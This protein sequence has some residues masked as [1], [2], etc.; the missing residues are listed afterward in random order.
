[1]VEKTT[2]TLSA[3]EATSE[4]LLEGEGRLDA[5]FYEGRWAWLTLQ[6]ID[7]PVER[8]GKYASVFYPGR[9]KRIFVNEANGVPFMGSRNIFL[10]PPLAEKFLAPSMDVVSSLYIKR[11]WTLITRSGTVGRALHAGKYLEP[12]TITED[13]IRVVPKNIEGGYL[14]AFLCSKYGYTLMSTSQF[15]AVIMHLEP[16]HIIN[17]PLPIFDEAE[18]VEI[19]KLMQRARVLRER[20]AC[21]FAKSERNLYRLTGLPRFEDVSISYLEGNLEVDAFEV[22]IHDLAGR[23]DA[24]Y[25]VPEAHAVQSVL[26]ESPLP[27]ARLGDMATIVI[28]PRFKRI[29]V[30]KTHGIRYIRP[31]DMVTIRLLEEKFISR[32]QKELPQLELNE[33]EVFVAT[34]GTV[35]KISYGGSEMTGWAGSNNIGRIRVRDGLHAGYLF[36]FLSSPYGQYQLKREIYGSVINHL[37]GEH[38]ANVEVLMPDADIQRKIGEPVLRAYALRDQANRLELEAI[39]KLEGLIEGG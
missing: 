3:V 32:R 7:A 39:E 21:L 38:V 5:A 31:S 10:Y 4:Q 19:D 28:P 8:L 23:L 29:Y 16:S 33:G 27:V 11:D 37:E 15:G 6:N 35:G 22:S 14:A 36:A 26:T 13:V 17:L 20:G 18:R 9:F 30:G 24:S 1:V 34:D 12:H 25:H 2:E